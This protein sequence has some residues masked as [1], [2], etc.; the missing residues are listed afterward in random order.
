MGF[1]H[2]ILISLVAASTTFFGTKYLNENYPAPSPVPTDSV[3]L[4]TPVP[5]LSPTPTSTPTPA[6]T[7][8]PTSKPTPT[9][10]PTPTTF[11]SAAPTAPTA[12]NT[13][14]PT[15]AP[16][17][18]P[19]SAPTPT[20]TLQPP[21]STPVQTT[22]LYDLTNIYAAQ[23]GVDPNTLRYIIQCESGFNPAATSPNG[24]YA[25]LFQFSAGT[26]TS[27][28]NLLGKNSDPALRYAAEDAIQTGAYA[29]SLTH[30]SIW[31]NCTP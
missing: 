27:Y 8:T 14:I 20:P 1:F 26:W 28:R 31:P 11:R 2:F 15:V 22:N 9:K 16:T 6:P 5:S 4:P 17:Q 30:G 21:T 7:A 10:T 24:L 3:Q 13:P 25:G 18:T 12:T 29:Y 19:T 23:Y